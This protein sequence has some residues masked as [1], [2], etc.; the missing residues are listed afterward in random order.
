MRSRG[1]SRKFFRRWEFS[2][3][4]AQRTSA[5]RIL[6]MPTFIPRGA[7]TLGKNAPTA[8]APDLDSIFDIISK[9]RGV[10]FDAAKIVAAEIIGRPDLIREIRKS[11]GRGRR[12]QT[13]DNNTA[14]AQHP[15]GCTLA[16]YAEAKQLK[17][18]ILRSFGLSQNHYLGQPALRIP[19]CGRD[20]ERRP[21][22][23]GSHWTART[24]FAGEK[25]TRRSFM[26]WIAWLPPASAVR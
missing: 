12:A 6:T 9:I 4:A 7:G 5:A 17:A 8:P 20:G 10:D 16:A 15:G 22:G 26:D 19:Y 1:K 21:Y 11:E 2:G 25:A 13:R 3:P 23:S 18:D 24:N 14:T